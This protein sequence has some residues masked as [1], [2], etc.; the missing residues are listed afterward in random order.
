MK[1]S[2]EIQKIPINLFSSVVYIR[3]FICLTKLVISTID[4]LNL[5]EPNLVKAVNF[6]CTLM[7]FSIIKSSSSEMLLKK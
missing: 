6:K 2:L 5:L 1:F 3:E 4:I 7:N